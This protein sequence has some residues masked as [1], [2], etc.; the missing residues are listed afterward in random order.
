MDKENADPGPP[1]D[2]CPEG[3]SRNQLSAMAERS[4]WATL[5]I[6]LTVAVIGAVTGRDDGFAMMALRAVAGVILTLAV[7]VLGGG[8]LW[9][10]VIL[11][12]HLRSPDRDPAMSAKIRTAVLGLLIGRTLIG[13][14][15]AL[16]FCRVT[17]AP[18]GS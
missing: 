4:I 18:G 15:A 14:S 3:L 9:T 13:L 6:L 11:W 2:H 1:Q 7:L 12:H 8:T 10:G 17:Q 5:A 16:H